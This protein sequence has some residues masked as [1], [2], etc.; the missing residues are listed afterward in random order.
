MPYLT[1]FLTTYA[2]L[3]LTLLVVGFYRQN[4]TIQITFFAT[5]AFFCLAWLTN[6]FSKQNFFFFENLLIIINCDY[7]SLCGSSS[8]IPDPFSVSVEHARL[9]KRA[10]V[11]DRV[12]DVASAYDA[13]ESHRRVM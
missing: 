11:S 12:S 7:L 3:L 1:Y 9:V 5:E 10:A 4:D 6:L 2:I 8:D 13:R